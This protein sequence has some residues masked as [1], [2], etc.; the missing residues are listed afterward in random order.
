M[1]NQN[2]FQEENI[3]APR[4]SVAVGEGGKA[5]IQAPVIL[6]ILLSMVVILGLGIFLGKIFFSSAG[7]NTGILATPTSI[8]SA[9]TAQPTADPT[10]NWKTYKNEKYGFEFKYPENVV[11]SKGTDE[12]MRFFQEIVKSAQPITF[13]FYIEKNQN[14]EGYT[15]KIKSTTLGVNSKIDRAEIKIG[16]NIFTK[17]SYPTKLGP[18]SI[19][20]TIQGKENLIIFYNADQILSTFKFL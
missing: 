17:L 3:P 18:S 16:E 1:Q 6:L 7:Q 10:A 8:V 14:L 4:P 11:N 13:G 20:F 12:E 19:E 9:P 2:Q 5:G 15:E